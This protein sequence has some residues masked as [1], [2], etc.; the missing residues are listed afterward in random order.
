MYTFNN[1]AAIREHTWKD[2]EVAIWVWERCVFDG[3]VFPERW[4]IIVPSK[5]DGQTSFTISGWFKHRDSDFY[6]DVVP[7]KVIAEFCTK[8]DVLEYLQKH[9]LDRVYWWDMRD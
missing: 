9:G 3:R 8:N 4:K 2:N 1:F 7:V 6:F 5:D